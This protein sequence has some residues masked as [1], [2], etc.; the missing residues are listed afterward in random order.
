MYH[1]GNLVRAIKEAALLVLAEQGPAALSLRQVSAAAGVSHTAPLHHFGD[2]RGL[3]TAI[4]IDGFESLAESLAR[5]RE[6]PALAAA[7]V[8][9]QL[10]NPGH[11]A[12]MWRTDLLRAD[13]PRLAEASLAAFRILHRAVGDYR[14]ALMAWSLAHGVSVLADRLSPALAEAAGVSDPDLPSPPELAA[15]FVVAARLAG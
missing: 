14:G 10:G 13:D 7:Y 4:A 6:L 1:H 3:L 15:Q 9:H 5:A 2:K 11:A 8:E 12:V